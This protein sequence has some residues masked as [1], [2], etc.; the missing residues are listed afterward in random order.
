M[1][2]RLLLVLAAILC[3]TSCAS[4]INHSE[5]ASASTA[6][7]Q[8]AESTISLDRMDAQF[9][10][11]AAQ[12]ALGRGQ[13]V[14]AM[15]FLSEVVKKKPED[16][17][18]RLDLAELY[19]MSRQ[20][21]EVKEAKRVL[22]TIP[23]ES[24]ASLQGERLTRYQLLSAQV[25]LTNGETEEATL[26]LSALLK[27][28]P[29]N[30]QIRLLLVRLHIARGEFKQGHALLDRGLNIKN[31]LLLWQ[32]RVQL[33]LKQGLINKA[34]QTLVKMQREY[35]HHEDIALQRSQL[36]EQQNEVLKSEQILKHYIDLHHDTAVQSYL[37]LAGLYVRQNQ[38]DE[39][40]KVYKSVLPYTAE[41]AD[42]YTLLG[43]VYYQQGKYLESTQVFE[44]A[45]LQLVH[46][47]PEQLNDIEVSVLFYLAASLEAS[48]RWAEAVPYYEKIKPHHELYVDAQLRLVNID[49]VNEKYLIAEKRLDTLK[50]SHPKNIDVFEMLTNLRLKQKAYKLLVSETDQA[51]D[52]GFSQVI[53]FNRAV[54]FEHLKQ[55]E[56]LDESL[57][58]LLGNMPEHAEALNFYGYSLADRGLRLDDALVMVNKALKIKPEDGYY[59]DSLAW[60]FFKQERYSEALE[61]QLRAEAK[62]PNDA[63][64]Q[65]HLG[66]I[67]WRT[68]KHDKAKEH[69][70]KALELEHEDA[71]K[72][73][74]KIKQGLM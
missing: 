58:G 57:E 44:Q 30:Q 22:D 43:K 9:L 35:P 39:A 71:G 19:L 13:Q 74:Q 23:P 40:V 4:T 45:R 32:M 48:H 11:L 36:A 21:S 6:V 61:T 24:K 16:I 63:V 69:W 54:A 7:K 5:P 41:S 26:L 1:N 37:S 49:L 14:L 73:R 68:E 15:R 46:S 60:I 3:L 66:D 47:D 18:P 55:F 52:L 56:Q 64:M 12:Q 28:Q 65:E 50:M 62:V 53:W 2:F 31:D 34:D 27:S 59:L 33:Y 10:Y 42:V 67:Y 25:M 29:E 17:E 72:I 20:I 51:L 38:L 70:Q 8:F